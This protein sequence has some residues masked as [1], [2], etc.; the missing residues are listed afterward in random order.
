[1]RIV[2]WRKLNKQGWWIHDKTRAEV[3]IEV[4]TKD[5]HIQLRKDG[6][7]RRLL[8]IEKTLQSA[9][10]KAVQIMRGSPNG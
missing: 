9:H 1:V 7:V 10:K 2:G 8:G 3:Y 5:Y 4:N 6:R